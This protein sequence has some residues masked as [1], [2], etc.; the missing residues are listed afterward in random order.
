MRKSLLTLFTLT[1][2]LSACQNSSRVETAESVPSATLPVSTPSPLPEATQTSSIDRLPTQTPA[3]ELRLP[4]F[5]VYLDHIDV[6]ETGIYALTIDDGYGKVPFDAIVAE[7]GSRKNQATFFLV[8]E[9]AVKLGLDR[10][11]SLADDG[12]T[13]AYHS[14]AHDDLAI[15]EEWT[16]LDWLDDYVAWEQALQRL[17]GD[18]LFAHLVRPYARAPYGLFNRPFLGMTEEIGLIPVGWSRDQGDLNIGLAVRPGDIF[19]IHVRILDAETL[20]ALLDEIELTPVSLDD[21]FAA[22]QPEE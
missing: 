2:Y 17:L 6:G 7:L 12:H 22:R 1:L 20:P 11:Q 16:E 5:G 21:L 8:A 4:Q 18:E 15:V 13:L 19:L 10:M 9:A 14:Y 3:A